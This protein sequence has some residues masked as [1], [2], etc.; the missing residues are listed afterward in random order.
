MTQVGERTRDALQFGPL[1]R[2]GNEIHT[3]RVLR[4]GMGGE[5]LAGRRRDRTKRAAQ[6]SC[7]ASGLSGRRRNRNGRGRQTTKRA[8]GK[9]SQSSAPL[10]NTRDLHFSLLE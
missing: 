4:T 5:I 2:M 3:N 10:I 7:G 1:L 8:C 6:P 9:Y